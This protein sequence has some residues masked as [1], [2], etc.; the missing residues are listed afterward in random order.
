MSSTFLNMYTYI[1]YMYTQKSHWL[2]FLLCFSCIIKW[3]FTHTHTHTHM[4]QVLLLFPHH[5]W[6]WGHCVPDSLAR[7]WRALNSQSG[8]WTPPLNHQLKQIEDDLVSMCILFSVP[9]TYT[10]ERALARQSSNAEEGEGRTNS[11]MQWVLSAWNIW[12]GCQPSGTNPPQF[13]HHL[14]S[15][16]SPWWLSW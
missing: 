6:G 14:I 7:M 1:I 13:E 4:G 11:E 15:L 2:Y 12:M 10:R 16:G 3:D 9:D 5:R 8:S